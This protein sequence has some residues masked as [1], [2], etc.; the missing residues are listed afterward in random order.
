MN[1]CLEEKFVIKLL[2]SDEKIEKSIINKLNLETLIKI[3]SQHLILP[4]FFHKIKQK[5]LL[6]FFPKDF[7]N[8]TKKI[9]EINKNRNI[10][11]I[12]EA[13]EINDLVLQNSMEIVFLKGT[14]MIF[15]K[16]Y[17]EIGVRMIGD[18]DFLIRFNEIKNIEN[19]LEINGYSKLSNYNFFPVRHLNR[20]VKENK[21][22]AIEPHTILTNKKI[23]SPNLV[24]KKMVN[25]DINI[26]SNLIMLKHNI[27][28]FMIND[29]ASSEFTYS[30]RSIYDT[31]LLLNNISEKEIQDDILVMNYISVMKYLGIK[32]EKFQN[33]KKNL[34]YYKFKFFNNS[35]KIYKIYLFLLKFYRKIKNKLKRVILFSHNN[36]YRDYIF[37]KYNKKWKGN[38][39]S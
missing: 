14:A 5:K 18:M 29:R 27:Y 21:I 8:Y 23:I 15:S 24:F 36:E 6:D 37:N 38:I 20:R 22:F 2:F 12:K 28:N 16:I 7:T 19:T 9:Y 35:K 31:Y 32:H 30:Y 17:S 11:L 39:F 33:M 34:F 4:L 26:P 13:K 25:C 10:H 1:I 3:L